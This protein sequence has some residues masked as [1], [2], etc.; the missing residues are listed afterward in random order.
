[1]TYTASHLAPVYQ[2]IDDGVPYDYDNVPKLRHVVNFGTNIEHPIHGWYY[3]K[4][5]FAV[6][7]PALP[8]CWS[9]GDSEEEALA[10]IQDA[11]QEYLAAIEDIKGHD[12]HR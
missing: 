2:E 9:Q 7:C 1:M 5:G 10:N 11:I 3:F 6:S 4:E 12:L 8:G